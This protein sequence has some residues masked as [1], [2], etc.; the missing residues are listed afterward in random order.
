MA[1]DREIVLMDRNGDER[2]CIAESF[3][4]GH[5]TLILIRDVGRRYRSRI[6][7]PA[8]GV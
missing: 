2:V 4:T 6:I 3:N 7:V 5:Q 1:F 8:V